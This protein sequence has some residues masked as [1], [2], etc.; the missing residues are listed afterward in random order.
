MDVHQLA[1][2]IEQSVELA[3]GQ[4]RFAPAFAN[5]VH[6]RLEELPRADAGQL[7][8]VLH[9][10]EHAGAGAVFGEPLDDVFAI[11]EYLAVRNGVLRASGDDVG[12]RAFAGAVGPHD[13]VDFAGGDRQADAFEYGGVFYRSAKVSDFEHFRS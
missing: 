6:R 12:E 4:L 2:G 10:E 11:V 1:L 7:H 3:D 8:R 5:G 13:G 9:G